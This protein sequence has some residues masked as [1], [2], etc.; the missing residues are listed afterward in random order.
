MK[1]RQGFVSNSSSSSFVLKV[2]N[3]FN[4]TLEVAKYMIPKRE[5]DNDN[6]LIE[7]IN[8]LQTKSPNIPSVCFRSCNYDTYIA[9]MDN[10][11]LISTCNNTD[12]DLKSTTIPPEEYY[13]YFGDDN[14]YNLSNCIN[15][16]HLD[17]DVIGKE[18]S[19]TDVKNWCET[20]Y[21]TYW[22]IDSKIQCP[23]CKKYY[24]KFNAL[25]VKNIMKN[26]WG[27]VSNSSSSSF[28]I[29]GIKQDYNNFEET[30]NKSYEVGLSAWYLE[31]YDYC[32]IGKQIAHWSD[33][34]GD[35]NEITLDRLEPLM[36]DVQS[37]IN[38][39]NGNLNQ[40]V[41]IFY[42]EMMC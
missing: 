33:G 34:E 22:W 42:G 38:K 40:I 39:M 11:F 4:T 15:F 26:R 25:N 32:L 12:W 37:K 20:C 3:P 27:F 24:E 28:V 35:I 17:Y 6:E 2:G 7:K 13:T 29:I 23:K 5:W 14:F 21:C 18:T 19:Y 41:S 10:L 1:I 9:K 8:K 16:Y 36:K 31:G 30:E